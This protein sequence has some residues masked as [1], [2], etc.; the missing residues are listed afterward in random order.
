VKKP[1]RL[2]VV[3]GEPSWTVGAELE[4]L[5]VLTAHQLRIFHAVQAL[6]ETHPGRGCSVREV[7]LAAGMRDVGL[8]HD[9]ICELAEMGF[10]TRV[11]GKPNTLVPR[12]RR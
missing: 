3:Q 12:F 6:Y 10:L 9:T 4:V 8:T 7:V 2:V 11:P 1:S 5:P